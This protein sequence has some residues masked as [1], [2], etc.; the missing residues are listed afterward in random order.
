MAIATV[1]KSVRATKAT[2]K[3]N[4]FQRLWLACRLMN[5]SPEDYTCFHKDVCGVAPAAFQDERLG[6]RFCRQTTV[7]GLVNQLTN[8]QAKDLLQKVDQLDRERDERHSGTSQ[9]QG[10]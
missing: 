1:R 10:R 3:V 5:L 9:C 2:E 8:R 7:P 4:L 6:G